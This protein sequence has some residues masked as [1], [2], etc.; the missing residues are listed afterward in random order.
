MKTSSSL[1]PLAGI[2]AFSI[3]TMGRLHDYGKDPTDLIVPPLSTKVYITLE[4]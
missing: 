1:G 4:K 2:L 3:F